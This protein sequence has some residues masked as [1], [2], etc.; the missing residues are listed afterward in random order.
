M[1]SGGFWYMGGYARYVWPSIGFACTV[2]VW[3]LW[4]ARRMLAAAKLRAR[5]TL[6]MAPAT[7]ASER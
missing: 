6:A 3:N 4:S 5:R 7:A 2:L 1:S